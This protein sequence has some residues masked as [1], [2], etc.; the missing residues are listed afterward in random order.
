M[1]SSI[2]LIFLVIYFSMNIVSSSLW[3]FNNLFRENAIPRTFSPY[4][5]THAYLHI[6]W[7]L[8]LLSH[9]KCTF[10]SK[11]YFIRTYLQSHEFLH[12]H[13]LDKLNNIGGIE[14][15]HLLLPHQ[16]DFILFCCILPVLTLLTVFTFKFCFS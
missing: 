16:I 13:V 12:C 10:E 5:M 4:I 9:K 2:N 14:L 11:T 7:K 3:S 8:R 1:S 6:N 15:M